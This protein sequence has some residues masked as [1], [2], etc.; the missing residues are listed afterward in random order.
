MRLPISPSCTVWAILHVFMLLTPPHFTL[1]LGMFPLDQIAHIG[2]N[3]SRCLKLF[4]RQII[5]EV[6]QPITVPERHRQTDR[7]TNT[8]SHRAVEANEVK[9]TVK[10]NE[11]SGDYATYERKS[12]FLPELE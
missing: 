11:I 3:V 5:S 6:F 1:I 9:K 12:E 10:R 4:G 7:R 8:Q 2:A